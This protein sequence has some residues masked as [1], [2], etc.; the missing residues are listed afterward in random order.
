MISDEAGAR[1]GESNGEGD[2]IEPL[3]FESLEVTSLEQSVPDHLIK[4]Y[5]E[6]NVFYFYLNYL[7]ACMTLGYI[8]TDP[9]LH[10]VIQHCHVQSK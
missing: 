7:L 8:T 5:D 6:V 1:S 9:Y 3:R 10:A 2:T 4:T